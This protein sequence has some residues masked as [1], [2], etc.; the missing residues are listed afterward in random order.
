VIGI[1]PVERDE[2]E[3]HPIQTRRASSLVAWVRIKINS[4]FGVTP[5]AWRF[6]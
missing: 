5:A 2:E 1:A 3:L 6:N 4:L